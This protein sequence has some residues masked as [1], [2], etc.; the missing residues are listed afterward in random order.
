[1]CDYR[2]GTWC[3]CVLR[4][5]IAH[6]GH[7]DDELARPPTE[8]RVACVEYDHENVRYKSQPSEEAQRVVP[9]VGD[10]VCSMSE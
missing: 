9:S 4:I 7:D 5:V 2:G 3:V 10:C 1:M 6:R 8:C